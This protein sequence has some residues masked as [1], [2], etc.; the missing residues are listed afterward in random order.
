[1]TWMSGWQLSS[2]SNKI[3][4]LYMEFLDIKKSTRFFLIKKRLFSLLVLLQVQVKEV[5]STKWLLF[6]YNDWTKSN[7]WFTIRRKS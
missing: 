5:N 3:I 1:M 7:E 6:E 4:V 2:V